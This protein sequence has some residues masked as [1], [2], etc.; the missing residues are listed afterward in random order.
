M[1]LPKEKSS[2]AKVLSFRPA[3]DRVD[4]AKRREQFERLNAEIEA[5]RRFVNSLETLS[6]FRQ[7]EPSEA[8]IMDALDQALRCVVEAT[9][10]DDGAVMIMDESNGDLIF[11]LT[12]G[13]VPKEKL[14]WKRVPAGRGAAQWVATH[15]RGAIVNSAL[16]DDRFYRGIDIASGYHTRSIVAVPLLDGD[17]AIGVIEVLNKKDG[18]FFSLSDQDHL[19][20]MAHLASGLLTKLRNREPGQDSQ[21]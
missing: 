13:N 19:T 12:Y 5:G 6:R 7:K 4:T 9:C 14:L 18:E 2:T 17:K 3:Q 10:A 21:K 1:A 16:N 15:R 20:L 8:E 11:A